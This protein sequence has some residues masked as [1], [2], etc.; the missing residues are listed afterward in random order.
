MC[1]NHKDHISALKQFIKKYKIKIYL[2]NKIFNSIDLEIENYQIYDEEI[3]IEDIN[4]R[5]IK[6]SHD[7]DEC[8]GFIFEYNNKDLV[9]ITDTGY[10]NQKYHELL[11]N[12][13]AYIIESNR[14]VDLLMQSYR[15]H[16]IKLRILGDDGHLSNNDCSYYLSKFIGDKTKNIYLAHLSEDNNEKSLAIKTFYK[17]NNYIYNIDIAQQNERTELVCICYELYL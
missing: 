4:V 15:P 7:V 10:I 17:N 11:K 9:Y 8:R 1:C 2:T 6:L 13:C 5:T 14:D 16:F 12:R 3:I